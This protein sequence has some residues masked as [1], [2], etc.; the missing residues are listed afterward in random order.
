MERIKVAVCGALDTAC[1]VLREEGVSHIDSYSDALDLA[2]RLKQG[3]KY[4]LIL[5]HAPFGEGLI[6]TEYPYRTQIQG[7]WVKVPVR[8]LNEPA[9]HSALVE[10]KSTV[11]SI[12]K[13]M[14]GT[15]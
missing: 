15:A 11:R 12:A 6:E 3:E 8:M 9:C 13:E 2:F 10:L 5:I 1:D 14:G 4:H 7:D